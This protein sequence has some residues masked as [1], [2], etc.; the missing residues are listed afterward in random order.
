VDVNINF[1]PN[2]E[3]IIF[4]TLCLIVLCLVIFFLSYVMI[5]EIYR[6]C[7]CAHL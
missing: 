5:C 6:I 7:K 1:D 4:L 3:V 2:M